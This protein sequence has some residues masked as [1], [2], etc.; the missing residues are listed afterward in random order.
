[1]NCPRKGAF[2]E[3]A[4]LQHHFSDRAED[5]VRLAQ[6]ARSAH[7][8]E[9]FIELARAWWGLLEEDQD[10]AGPPPRKQ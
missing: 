1:M 5:C 3:D 6:R 8:K 2:Q 10:P 7:D 9:L 4:M